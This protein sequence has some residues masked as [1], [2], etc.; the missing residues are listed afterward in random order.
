MRPFVSDGPIA[1]YSVQSRDLP[2]FEI[3]PCYFGGTTLCVRVLT[4][5]NKTAVG[6]QLIKRGLH[7]LI[8]SHCLLISSLH[9]FGSV[10]VSW[11]TSSRWPETNGR[12]MEIGS[13]HGRKVRAT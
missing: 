9:R 1:N 4:A 8:G 10:F 11:T 3:D 12:I 13:G 2:L 5:G 6:F 7:V